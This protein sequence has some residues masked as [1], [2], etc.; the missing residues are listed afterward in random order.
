MA[1][2]VDLNSLPVYH[3][4]TD[5]ALLVLENL[6]KQG[7]LVRPFP[8]EVMR[9]IA[10]ELGLL[11]EADEYDIFCLQWIKNEYYLCALDKEALNHENDGSSVT[12]YTYCDN[13]VD[14]CNAVY[15]VIAP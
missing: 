10:S 6:A 5:E 2:I 9:F 4:D 8:N 3:V 14:F 1:A 11:D 12:V 15:S 13:L 7:T